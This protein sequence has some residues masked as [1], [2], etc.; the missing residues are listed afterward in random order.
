M[1]PEHEVS[2]PGEDNGGAEGGE[3]NM[4]LDDDQNDGQYDNGNSMSDRGWGH[5]RGGWSSGSDSHSNSPFVN[6]NGSDWNNTSNQR[7]NN[8]NWNT[9]GN[10]GFKTG[11]FQQT[12]PPALPSLM[13]ISVPP[14]GAN[15]DPMQSMA[16]LNDA[17]KKKLPSWIR[18]GLEKMER[19]KLKKEQDDERKRRFEERKRLEKLERAEELK[20]DPSKSKFDNANSDNDSDDELEKAVNQHPAKQRKSRFE[21]AR[22]SDEPDSPLVKQ[23]DILQPVEKSKEEILAEMSTQLRMLMTSLLLEV[24][25]EEIEQISE[26]VIEKSQ[27]NSNSKPKLQSLLSGYGSDDSSASGH[28]DD[29]DSEQELKYSLSKKKKEFS[30]VKD[31]ILE[32][33]AEETAN[34][35]AKEKQWLSGNKSSSKSRSQTPQSTRNRIIKGILWIFLLLVG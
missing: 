34:Y 27:K 26:E 18:A 19:D 22:E 13:D 21:E 8:R 1:M 12:Y 28:S 7:Q 4:E 25:A 16:L 3:A 14:V 6:R 33:C 5:D 31:E 32:F 20:K 15:V 11:H 17:Q 10:K 23:P 29:E 35:K 30:Y 9:N 2:V 24:T